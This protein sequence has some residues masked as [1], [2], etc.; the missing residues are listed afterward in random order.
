M[1]GTGAVRVML[2]EDHAAFRQAL[3]FLLSGE[4]DLE[5]VA[6]AGSLTEA[7]QALRGER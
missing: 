7:R 5:V 1:G 4:P 6:E 3:A 2:V